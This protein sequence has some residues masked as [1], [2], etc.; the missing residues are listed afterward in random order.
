MPLYDDMGLWIDST[1][2]SGTN[3]KYSNVTGLTSTPTF[4]ALYNYTSVV[5]P[6]STSITVDGYM[7]T[8]GEC[9]TLDTPSITETPII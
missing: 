5:A 1:G 9:H 8:A 2:N 7:V 4:L 3:N 6:A